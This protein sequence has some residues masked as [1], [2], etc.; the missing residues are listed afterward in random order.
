[1]ILK[2]LI[3]CV[4]LFSLVNCFGQNNII[5]IG[6]EFPNFEKKGD[7]IS[8]DISSLNLYAEISW[9]D[10]IC[11]QIPY[12]KLES[13]YYSYTIDSLLKRWKKKFTIDDQ[14]KMLSQKKFYTIL[15][16]EMESD[17]LIVLPYEIGL[18]E[19][20]EFIKP[21]KS[22]V[23]YSFTGEYN[24]RKVVLFQDCP[25]LIFTDYRD[26]RIILIA[27]DCN[28]KGRAIIMKSDWM[29]FDLPN[30]PYRIR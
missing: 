10:N 19:D 15:L 30:G 6:F 5:K 26:F 9:N 23:E 13:R 4:T 25:S 7:D 11:L 1:M 14:I 20:Y 17:T 8:L 18:F 28:K 3:L 21:D 16:Q 27:R 12:G 22:F 29:N 24:N 2:F